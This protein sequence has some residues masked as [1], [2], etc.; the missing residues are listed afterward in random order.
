MMNHPHNEIEKLET[1]I[2]SI[3]KEK[4]AV[5]KRWNGARN[6]IFN[7]GTFLVYSF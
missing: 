2:T 5:C 3:M 1:L 7:G 4:R 6:R